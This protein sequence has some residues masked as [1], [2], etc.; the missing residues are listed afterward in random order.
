MSG[1][2]SKCWNN[3]CLLK[4]EKRVNV[5]EITTLLFKTPLGIGKI[6]KCTLIDFYAELYLISLCNAD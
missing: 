4:I 2:L 6:D 5:V 1:L 3:L